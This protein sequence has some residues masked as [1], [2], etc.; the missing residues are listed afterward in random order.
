[1]GSFHNL[2][3]IDNA[4]INIGCMY[5]FESVFL[6]PLGKNLGEQLLDD[7]VFFL[8][9]FLNFLRNV[10]AVWRVAA[11]V[12]IPTNSV[13]R[14]PFSLRSYQHLLFPVLVILAILTD[15]R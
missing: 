6:Y 7:R 10:H 2:A 13:R 12:C 15:V 9:F 8:T 3:I 11:P 4:A 5:C 14:L 1:M